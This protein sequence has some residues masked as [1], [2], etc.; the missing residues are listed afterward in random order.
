MKDDPQELYKEGMMWTKE[1][2]P[3]PDGFTVILMETGISVLRRKRQRNLQKL[4]I[5]GFLVRM[6]GVR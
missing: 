1:D 4:G 3:P 5:G 2:G 6:R